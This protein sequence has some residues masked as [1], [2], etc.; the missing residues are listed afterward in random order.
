VFSLPQKPAK[1]YAYTWYGG[2]NDVNFWL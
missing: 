2:G 1:T